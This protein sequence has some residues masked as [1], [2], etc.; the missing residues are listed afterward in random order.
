MGA[1][2]NPIF[3]FVHFYALVK[4]D[5]HVHKTIQNYCNTDYLSTQLYPTHQKMHKVHRKFHAMQDHIT[6]GK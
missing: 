5:F 1:S 4:N 6:T 3:N 2:I